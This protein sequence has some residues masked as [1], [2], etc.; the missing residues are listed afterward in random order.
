MG[1]HAQQNEAVLRFGLRDRTMTDVLVRWPGGVLERLD[2]PRVGRV[3]DVPH[4]DP[5]Q[6]PNLKLA[7]PEAEGD[8]WALQAFVRGKSLWTWAFDL[9][10]DGD[11]ETVLEPSSQGVRRA[12]VSDPDVR[13]VAGPGRARRQPGVARGGLAA[14]AARL[15]RGQG[16]PV[17]YRAMRVPTTL[18]CLLL[19]APAGRLRAARR[20]ST[21][22]TSTGRCTSP[23]TSPGARR[24]G[25]TC[26]RRSAPRPIPCCERCENGRQLQGARPPARARAASCWGSQD[27]ECFWKRHAWSWGI[28]VQPVLGGRGVRPLRRADRRTRPEG[29]R[30]APEPDRD[31]GRLEQAAALDRGLAALLRRHRHPPEAQG[32]D[33]G[34][35][36]AGRLGPRGGAP[37]RAALRAGLQRLRP[38]LRQARAA[39]ASRWPCTCTRRR[40]TW[41]RSRRSYLGSPR[42]DMLYGGGSNRIAGGFAGNGFVASLQEQRDDTE[43]PRALPTHDRPHPVLVLAEGERRREGLPQ[44]G[45]SSAWRTSWRSCSPSRR[46]TSPSARNETTA[47][48]GQRQGLGQEGEGARAPQPGPDRDVLRPRVDGRLVVRGPRPRVVDHGPHAQGG[49]R[50]LAEGARAAP[51]RRGRG[52]RV[53]ERPRDHARRVQRALEGPPHRQAPDDGRDPSATRARARRSPGARERRRIRQTEDED[54]LAGLIRGLDR[55]DDVKT[56]RVVV[57]QL[58]HDVGPRP[59]DDPGRARCARRTPEVM[60]YLLGEALENTGAAGAG[61]RGARARHAEVR[62]RREGPGVPARGPALAGARRGGV[63]ASGRSATRSRSRS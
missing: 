38:L 26:G 57:E 56:A 2:L 34:R 11:F 35:R 50:A 32:P 19:V 59:R 24:A 10:G 30:D 20:S 55:I 61:R 36:A 9:D 14:A 27:E 28:R 4:P 22:T 46:T 6:V 62:S 48:T 39:S 40:A 23:R 42:T 3:H 29:P 12:V 8:G 51:R 47:P 54:V 13:E 25:R 53:Q 41:S 15:T 1:S 52:R 60:E 7:A 21:R 33:R 58:D 18:L 45:A 31:R 5:K 63:G 16:S 49:S 43:P 44:V 37:L 17:H